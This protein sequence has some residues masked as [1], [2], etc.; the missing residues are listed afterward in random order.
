MPHLRETYL[1]LVRAEVRF[2]SSPSSQHPVDPATERLSAVAVLQA[3]G[4]TE[5]DCCYPACWKQAAS[6]EG[7]DSCQMDTQSW[8]IGR[9]YYTV[10]AS[11]GPSSSFI[12]LHVFFCSCFLCNCH[13]PTAWNFWVLL[14]CLVSLL[15]KSQI[16]PWANNPSLIYFPGNFSNMMACFRQGT[17]YQDILRPVG[18]EIRNR[19]F[20]L[21]LC[22]PSPVAS[23][24]NAHLWIRL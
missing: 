3:H 5:A 22:L 17:V 1:S 12:S 6:K 8:V 20:P 16:T 23:L 13:L 2:L 15:F 21:L 18:L 24:E 11:P 10:S 9:L 14:S 7:E 4:S 19:V